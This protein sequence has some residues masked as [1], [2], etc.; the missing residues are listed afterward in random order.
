MFK[1]WDDLSQN[2]MT[3]DHGF[4]CC[5]LTQIQESIEVTEVNNAINEKY[6]G[7]AKEEYI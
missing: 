7:T 3:A 2:S 5:I 6:Y 1:I 4:I